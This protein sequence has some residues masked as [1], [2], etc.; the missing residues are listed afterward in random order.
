MMDDLVDM[1]TRGGSESSRPYCNT[2][3]TSKIREFKKA[4]SENIWCPRGCVP[5][6]LNLKTANVR[7]MCLSL[8]ER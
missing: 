8:V 4:S 2:K 1:R 5:V 3:R 7:R 6:W